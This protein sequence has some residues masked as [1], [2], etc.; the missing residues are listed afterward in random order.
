MSPPRA[1]DSPLEMLQGGPVPQL[2]AQPTLL[3][4]A[5]AVKKYKEDGLI[6]SEPRAYGYSRYFCALADLH[7][8]F[9]S[10]SPRDASLCL[11]QDELVLGQSLGWAGLWLALKLTVGSPSPLH[12]L[13]SSTVRFHCSEVEEFESRYSFKSPVEPSSRSDTAAREWLPSRRLGYVS[14]VQLA[15]E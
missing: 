10:V 11:A 8:L 12:A 4:A 15:A 1:S 2:V 5:F 3:T 14:E 9:C 13:G 6:S 7:C